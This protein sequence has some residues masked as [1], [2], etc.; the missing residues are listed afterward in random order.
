MV[1]NEVPMLNRFVPVLAALLASTA[2]PSLAEDEEMV[3]LSDEPS[4]GELFEKLRP[5]G[6]RVLPTLFTFPADALHEGP[7]KPRKNSF[8]GID[9]SHHNEGR[10]NCKIDWSAF[11]KQNVHF[12]Y[13]KATQGKK[14]FDP[15]FAR[16]WKAVGDLPA[17]TSLHRGAYHFLSSDIEPKA[18]VAHFLKVMPKLQAS[19][20]PPCLDLEWDMQKGADGKSSDAWAKIKPD[21][22]ADR[23]LVWL[24]EIE[25]AT[26]R[27][28]IIYTNRSWWYD[29][30]GADRLADFDKYPIWIA[31]YSVSRLATEKP[32]SFEH[33]N[34][35]LWQFT[36]KAKVKINGNF[37]EVDANIYKGEWKDFKKLVGIK[38]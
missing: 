3:A 26:G 2:A 8:F 35:L 29:R 5:E 19:D 38:D 20:M 6:A 31:D 17:D 25:K 10:C 16:Q 18:Q 22:I 15:T 27:T 11:K 1:T 33:R 7:G 28:P 30:I 12:V 24:E 9:I 13:L 34:W 23:A 4:R 36:E 32:R 37:S 21:D 14:F